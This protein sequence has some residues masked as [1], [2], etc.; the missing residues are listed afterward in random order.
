[1]MMA[2]ERRR[3]EENHQN[4]INYKNKI[5]NED[6]ENIFCFVNYSICT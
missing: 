1:M 4:E 3:R 5:N 2:L 6:R